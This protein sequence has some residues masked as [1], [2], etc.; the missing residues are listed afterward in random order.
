MGGAFV[1]QDCE[2]NDNDWDAAEGNHWLFGIWSRMTYEVENR[3]WSYAKY[4][5]ANRNMYAIGK[6][7]RSP[8]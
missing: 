5:D 8:I 3:E 4:D 1:D 7:L 2:A 6:G